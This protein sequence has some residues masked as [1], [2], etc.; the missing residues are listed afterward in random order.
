MKSYLDTNV[1]VHPILFDNRKAAACRKLLEKAARREIEA[2]TSVLTWDELVYVVGKYRGRTGGNVEGAKFLQFPHL[3]F[4]EV[5]LPLLAK[6]QDLADRY[7]LLPRDA[8]HAA[9]ALQETADQFVSDDE[10]FDRVR[11]LRR[12]P[13]TG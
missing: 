11:E 4:I 12:V 3:T 13:V 8:V 6:A 5:D 7:G 2:V 10:D 9:S 1:F